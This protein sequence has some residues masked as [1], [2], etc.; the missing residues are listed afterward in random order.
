MPTSPLFFVRNGYYL[1]HNATVIGNVTIGKDSNF[2]FGT[3]MRGD[4][5]PITIGERV[6]I[7]DLSMVHCDVDVPQ[8]IEDDVVAGHRVI[9]HG[10]AKV[11]SRFRT[12]G[13]TY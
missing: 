6:N 8:V 3:V 1:A 4:I 9:L 12:P 5:E 10:E 7:Q 11:L 13:E 2:W